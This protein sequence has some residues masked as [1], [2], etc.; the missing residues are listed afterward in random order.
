MFGSFLIIAILVIL[1][2][3]GLKY[4]NI[5]G[6]A[7]AAA[8]GD[9]L[10]TKML[11]DNASIQGLTH[12]AQENIYD[13]ILKYDVS[14]S[15]VGRQYF[16]IWNMSD[17]ASIPNT[18]KIKAYLNNGAKNLMAGGIDDVQ[19]VQNVQD[20][21]GFI[22]GC[23]KAV[24]DADLSYGEIGASGCKGSNSLA[25]GTNVTLS[26]TTLLAT[27]KARGKLLT[28]DAKRLVDII[29][30]P[31]GDTVYSGRLSAV[32]MS[33]VGSCS[34]VYDNSID[35]WIC[36]SNCLIKNDDAH[37]KPGQGNINRAGKPLE[38]H[39]GDTDRLYHL[40]LKRFI[41]HGDSYEFR[42]DSM[43]SMYA[44]PS[45]AATEPRKCKFGQLDPVTKSEQ[46]ICSGA[47]AVKKCQILTDVGDVR[48]LPE[49]YTDPITKKRYKYCP[50]VCTNKHGDTG[51]GVCRT[52]QDCRSHLYKNDVSDETKSTPHSHPIPGVNDGIGY[53]RIE[54]D[55]NDQPSNF[56]IAANKAKIYGNLMSS[57]TL[58][59]EGEAEVNVDA[60][61]KSTLSGLFDHVLNKMPVKNLTNFFSGMQ[62]YLGAS[63]LEIKEETEWLNNSSNY[64]LSDKGDMEDSNFA[65]GGSRLQISQLADPLVFKNK[66]QHIAR[67]R[68]ILY[69]RKKASGKNN[70][71]L[72]PDAIPK[73]AL[74]ALGKTEE[75]ITKIVKELKNEFIS[76]YKRRALRNQL[77]AEKD[78]KANLINKIELGEISYESILNI[79]KLD[80]KGVP[81]Q[82]TYTDLSGG[83]QVALFKRDGSA[84]FETTDGKRGGMMG[85]KQ[86]DSGYIPFKSSMPKYYRTD[87]GVYLQT[88]GPAGQNIF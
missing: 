66:N 3:A 14:L 84:A 44:M 35:G 82:A 25:E 54:V 17:V 36:A 27:G 10:P 65:T 23:A 75:N 15:S 83:A 22:I 40:P 18:L 8:G 38:G 29:E 57:Q 5:E 26:G 13:S 19:N 85:F 78:A 4:K 58:D 70:R 12:I 52:N 37:N 31:K 2:V 61:E 42:C 62:S 9:S 55:E 64:G 28:F 77:V 34:I 11:V 50:I 1:V 46:M 49:T 72:N 32:A 69:A 41:K 71:S 47:S 21:S 79:D 60:L 67:G 56:N 76:K 53:T 43:N 88:P 51:D 48:C 33:N 87:D 7:S 68:E 45:G 24:A 80:S 16:D 81:I 74:A 86:N 20:I 39:L 6:F 73:D 30:N 63:A 59:P